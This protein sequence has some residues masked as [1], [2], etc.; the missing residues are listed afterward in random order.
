MCAPATPL[1]PRAVVLSLAVLA[2]SATVDPMTSRRRDADMPK[3]HLIDEA[4]RRGG[5]QAGP[6]TTV[7]DRTQCPSAVPAGF[8]V[9]PGACINGDKCTGLH[10]NCDNR[11]LRHGSC[12]SNNTADACFGFALGNCTT[13]PACHGFAMQTGCDKMWETF[14]F[15]DGYAYLFAPRCTLHTAHTAGYACLSAPHCTLHTPPGMRA[16]LP[17]TAH[18]AHRRNSSGWYV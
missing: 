11:Q 9:T 5:S 1:C 16:S 2:V 17:H 15:G 6:S 12:A 14:R 3:P 10:C 18:C 4:D 13:D 8:T 7:T